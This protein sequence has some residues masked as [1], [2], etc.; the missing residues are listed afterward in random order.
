M[1]LKE[2]R[3]KIGGNSLHHSA[4]AADIKRGCKNSKDVSAEEAKRLRPKQIRKKRLNF[5]ILSPL[6]RAW[7]VAQCRFKRDPV[8]A[9]TEKCNLLPI[10]C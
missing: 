8:I 3:L 4:G 9:K 10:L 6:R 5:S 7:A 2:N 1:E